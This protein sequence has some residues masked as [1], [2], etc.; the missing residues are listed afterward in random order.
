MQ[1]AVSVR[2]DGYPE[3]VIVWAVEEVLLKVLNFTIVAERYEVFLYGLLVRASMFF[4]S[5]SRIF[6]YDHG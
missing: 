3:V 6:L 4:R 1:R 5:H 2:V